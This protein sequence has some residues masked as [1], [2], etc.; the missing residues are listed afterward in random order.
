MG[1]LGWELMR[2]ILQ[3]WLLL[4]SVTTAFGAAPSEY[5]LTNITG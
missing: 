1:A 4:L 3:M 5:T 2:K